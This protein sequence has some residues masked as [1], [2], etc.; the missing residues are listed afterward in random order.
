MG[1]DI[2]EIPL[3]ICYISPY[4]VRKDP[5]D[6]TELIDSIRD[7][8]V[9]E[10]ILVRQRGEEYQVIAGRRRLEA[11]RIVGLQ[12][13]PASVLEVTDLQLILTSLIEN[14]QRKD[15]TLAERVETY[16]ALR[17]CD[18]EYQ[19]HQP[20]PSE[21]YPR[22]PGVSGASEACAPRNHGGK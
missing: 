19:S 12:T 11:A 13:I 14:I 2:K 17:L 3:D 21:D 6:L 18:A 22:F 5:G 7:R 20:E 15:L 1:L 10:P 9:L 16:Q 8:G 4:N